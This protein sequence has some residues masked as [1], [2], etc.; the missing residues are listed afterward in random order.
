MLRATGKDRG[1]LFDNNLRYPIGD[2]TERPHSLVVAGDD[3]HS[4]GF[5]GPPEGIHTTLAN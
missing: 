5:E 3:E 1:V 2:E 4:G